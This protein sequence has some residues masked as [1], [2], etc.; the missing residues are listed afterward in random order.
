M[1][2]IPLLPA[3]RFDIQHYRDYRKVLLS[4]I[5][6][7]DVLLHLGAQRGLWLVCR[8]GRAYNVKLNLHETEMRRWAQLQDIHTSEMQRVCLRWNG[9]GAETVAGRA[10]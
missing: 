4:R 2:S 5:T 7:G 10:A 6:H 3:P 1:N 8:I 9:G